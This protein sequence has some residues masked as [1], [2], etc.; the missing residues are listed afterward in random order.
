MMKR[1]L[2]LITLAIGI[3]YLANARQAMPN[4]HYKL[5]KGNSMVQMTNYYLLTLLQNDIEVRKLLRYGMPNDKPCISTT[6]AG[7]SMMITTTL[8]A[9]CQ[10][11]L[12]EV[13]FKAGKRLSE[14]E[15][16]FIPVID[17]LHINPNEPLDP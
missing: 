13:P 5:I 2:L 4:A 11:E 16:E 1:I 6:T 15:A 8:A 10:K 17:A 9:R 12:N 3:G 14:T 7:Q